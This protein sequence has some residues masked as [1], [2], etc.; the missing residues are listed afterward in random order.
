MTSQSLYYLGQQNLKHKI[1]S[2]AEEEGVRDASYQLKLLQ[3]EGSLSLVS[4]SKEKGSGRTSTERYTVEGPIALLLTTTASDID[5][6]LLNRCLVVSV[7]ESS[8]Q[9]VAILAQQRYAR[10]QQG[11][12][13]QQQALA[14][15]ALHRNAQRLLKPLRV[16]NTYAEQLSFIGSQTRYRRDHQ[17]YLTLIDTIALLHQ[18]ST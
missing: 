13:K 2:I 5:P 12:V 15:M 7:D 11:F 9:T 14:I 3:S 1:L 4:T 16:Y 6:E 18:V 8:A 17:K 10:T